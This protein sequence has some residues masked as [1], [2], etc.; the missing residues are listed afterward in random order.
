ML[1]YCATLKHESL[2]PPLPHCP[3]AKPTVLSLEPQNTLYNY[4]KQHM[5]IATHRNTLLVG[6]DEVASSDSSG[7][8]IRALDVQCELN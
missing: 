5:H 3:L 7:S 2:P 1:E 8:V 6:G 4:A